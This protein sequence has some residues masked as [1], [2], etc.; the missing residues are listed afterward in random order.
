MWTWAFKCFEWT[1]PEPFSQRFV[2][3]LPG[4][5][6]QKHPDEDWAETFA[7]W[8][9]PHFNWRAAYSH[10]PAALAKLEYCDRTMAVVNT[11]DPAMTATELDEDVSDISKSLDDYYR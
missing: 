2:R 9:T 5:Y 1:C 7:V 6:A 4:W 11:R 8:M 10:W 3:N